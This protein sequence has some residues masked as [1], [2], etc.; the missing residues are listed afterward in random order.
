MLFNHEGLLQPRME[1]GKPGM[2]E[3]IE[4]A[5]NAVGRRVPAM[6]N[7]EPGVLALTN[8]AVRAVLV[9]SVAGGLITKIESI[10]DPRKLRHLGPMA[11]HTT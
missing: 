1:S 9:L 8:Q 7:G 3:R 4:L 2:T 11:G 10:V 5:Y 6:V